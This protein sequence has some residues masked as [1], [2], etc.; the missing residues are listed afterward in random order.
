ML[1]AEVV[2]K[3]RRGM[4]ECIVIVEVKM[5]RGVDEE[6]TL[7]RLLIYILFDARSTALVVCTLAPQPRS[8][9]LMQQLLQLSQ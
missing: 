5:R 2:V 7:Q 3:K 6:L 4:N 1:I 8:D 9:W